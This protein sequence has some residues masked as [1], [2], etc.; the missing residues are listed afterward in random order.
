MLA[1]A[2]SDW[3]S[4]P[5]RPGNLMSSTR[6]LGLSGSFVCRNSGAEPNTSAC[7]PTDLN[8]L[9]RASHSETSSSITHTTGC[10]MS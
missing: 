4:S 10:S 7:K 1:L 9:A 8:K 3:K 6:Q 2:N 5:L